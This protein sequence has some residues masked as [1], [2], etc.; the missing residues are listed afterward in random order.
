MK[1]RIWF[2]HWFNTAYHIVN[3]L[4]QGHEEEFEIYGTNRNPYSAVLTACDYSGIE[5]SMSE[6][7]YIDFCLDF[8][9]RNGIDVFVPRSN[10][11]AIVK[12][13][14]KFSDLG[15]KLLVCCNSNTMNILS[16]KA[17]FYEHL[18][19]NPHFHIPE[20]RIV[21]NFTDFGK[22]YEE[23]KDM[24]YRVCFKPVFSEGAAGFRVIDEG[25][26]SIENLLSVISHKVTF[27]DAMNILSRKERFNDL[28]V[29]EY[30]GGYE[31]SIDCLAF[32]GKLLSAVPRK[33]VDG[34]VRLLE[35]SKEFTALAEEMTRIFHLS[36]VF[37]IQ[38]RMDGD[39]PKI[40][41]LNPRMS[42]GIWISC[43]SEINFPYLAV[44][45]LL[46]G[47]S[48]IDLPLP[49]YNIMVTQIEK[50]IVILPK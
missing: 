1:K 36:F 33:K 4:K 7:E 28:M 15:V 14:G 16:D 3:L 8:C 50:E 9:K 44:K 47:D 26:G 38:V 34:R 22:A 18:R 20:Y 17:G 41:E 23:L 35:E 31:Y 46:E 32:N 21:N 29:M 27:R 45:L 12:N 24:G 11:K 37:N 30:I 49:K 25:A 6:G 2:N 40:L 19:G 42:G 10:L 13:S 48:H 39:C 43:L 5:E